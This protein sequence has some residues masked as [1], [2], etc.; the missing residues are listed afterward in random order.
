MHISADR[1][2]KLTLAIA[3]EVLAQLPPD[4]RADAEQ[5]ILDIADRPTPEQ[6]GRG[7]YTEGILLGLYEGVPL[8]RRRSNSVL[9]QPDRIT[10]FRLAIASMCRTEVELKAQIRKTLV[11]ELGHYF[12]FS[13]DELEARGWA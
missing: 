13:E 8:V 1:F 5:V 12:G 11:H 3:D 4:L 6:L 9:L 10:L 7:G 2:E